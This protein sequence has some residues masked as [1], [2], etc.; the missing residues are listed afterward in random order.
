[1]VQIEGTVPEGKG[2][3]EVILSPRCDTSL[4]KLTLESGNKVIGVFCGGILVRTVY[5]P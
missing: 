4:T 1:M 2:L 5:D 3:L